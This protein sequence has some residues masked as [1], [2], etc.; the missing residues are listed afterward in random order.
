MRVAKRL[1]AVGTISDD[2]QSIVSLVDATGYFFGFRQWMV[3]FRL[4]TKGTADHLSKTVSTKFIISRRKAEREFYRL[5]Y[6]FQME[7]VPYGYPPALPG[8]ERRL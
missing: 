4:R 8:E 7:E 1:Q 2:V 6:L 3:H 5:K